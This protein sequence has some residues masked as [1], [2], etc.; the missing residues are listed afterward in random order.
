MGRFFFFAFVVPVKWV[1]A[2]VRYVKVFRC[3]I[4]N[5]RVI[6]RI[7]VAIRLTVD[8]LYF[9]F[10]GFLFTRDK[11][12]FVIKTPLAV[13]VRSGPRVCGG[14]ATTREVSRKGRRLKPF[15][16]FK[17]RTHTPVLPPRRVMCKIIASRRLTDL[18]RRF[19]ALGRNNLGSPRV[20]LYYIYYMRG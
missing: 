5:P 2:G 8:F 18:S 13:V 17:S 7:H 3:V 20:V 6:V 4:T 16:T 11:I 12:K 10:L 15:G 19:Y 9:R 14:G 1:S